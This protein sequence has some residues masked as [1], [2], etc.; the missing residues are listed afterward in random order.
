MDPRGSLDYQ[1]VTFAWAS[2]T[3]TEVASF[4]S[5]L[6]HLMFKNPKY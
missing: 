4:S 5:D 2:V 1:I 6:G 3:T